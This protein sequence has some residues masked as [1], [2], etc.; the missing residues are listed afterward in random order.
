MNIYIESKDGFFINPDGGKTDK[1]DFEVGSRVCFQSVGWTSVEYKGAALCGECIFAT[2]QR[3]VAPDD[4]VCSGRLFRG[5]E[6]EEQEVPAPK[7]AVTTTEEYNTIDHPRHYTDVVPG[8]ECI[9]VTEH[10][11]FLLGNAIK[12]IWRSGRKDGNT[13]LQDLKKA[14]WYIKRAIAR[15]SK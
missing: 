10:F 5:I 4:L 1:P 6:G 13:K 14:E 15:E 2:G 12:Y 8:I 11:D 7:A 9:Q 3:C